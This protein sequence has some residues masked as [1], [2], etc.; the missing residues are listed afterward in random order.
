MFSYS[1]LLT[2]PLPSTRY[3]YRSVN[4][5][6]S[7]RGFIVFVLVLGADEIF[8]SWS[9]VGAAGI[10]ATWAG[11]ERGRVVIDRMLAIVDKLLSKKGWFYM[12]TLTANN[13]SEICQIMKSKGFESRILIQV[14]YTFSWYIVGIIQRLCCDV[15]DR[16]S[17]AALW[18]KLRI[19]VN[20]SCCCSFRFGV[21]ASIIFDIVECSVIQRKKICLYWSSGEKLAEKKWHDTSTNYSTKYFVYFHTQ[22]SPSRLEQVLRYA[23]RGKRNES[24]RGAMIR[25]ATCQ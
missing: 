3:I 4:A 22:I 21:A 1:T 10:T 24:N 17:H 5:V 6:L 12:I 15:N 8:L 16:L 25:N 2:F 11:G 19:V 9:Q 18:W 23:C 7:R 20:L 14:L 13:P